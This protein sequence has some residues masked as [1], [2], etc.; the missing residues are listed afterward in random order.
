[1]TLCEIQRELNGH[2]VYMEG[3]IEQQI[4]GPIFLKLLKLRLLKTRLVDNMTQ[5]AVPESP[6]PSASEDED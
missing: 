2:G 4:L 3:P 1:M 6:S 5:A